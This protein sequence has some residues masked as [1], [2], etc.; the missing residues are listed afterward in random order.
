MLLVGMLLPATPAVDPQQI[1]Q[2]QL[3]V[4]RLSQRSRDEIG[5]L[6]HRIPLD[7]LAVWENHQWRSPLRNEAPGRDSPIR[8][9]HLW[10]VD[11]PPCRYELPRLQR[12]GK[13]LASDHKRKIALVMVS[14]SVKSEDMQRFEKLGIQLTGEQRGD[15]A[16]SVQRALMQA[17]PQYVEPA[18]RSSAP[19]FGREPPLPVTVVLDS[20]NVVRLAFVGSLEGRHGELVAAVERLVQSE[21]ERLAPPQTNR[22]LVAGREDKNSRKP[23]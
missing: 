15:S 4:D 21:Q 14:E 8:I 22:S 11:C 2:L 23:Q 3:R 20:E 1:E 5:L 18:S 19:H 13:Q 6:N 12:I 16:G 17:L 7:D 9:V 10:S